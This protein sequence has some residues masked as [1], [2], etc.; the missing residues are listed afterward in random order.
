MFP[1]Y[2]RLDV[3]FIGPSLSVF[4]L[5]PQPLLEMITDVAERT[6]C[7]WPIL[8][9]ILGDNTSFDFVA[10]ICI[11]DVICALLHAPE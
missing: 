10:G 4:H 3:V 8:G 2:L 7:S 9:A 1:Q 6:I 5:F 11:D